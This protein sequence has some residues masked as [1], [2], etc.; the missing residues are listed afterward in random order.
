LGYKLVENQ[1]LA[2]LSVSQEN[3]RWIVELHLEA[4]RMSPVESA[5]GYVE[6]VESAVRDSLRQVFGIAI[7]PHK[8]IIK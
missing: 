8:L 4:I 5:V 1:G 6:I 2:G 3:L 7:N